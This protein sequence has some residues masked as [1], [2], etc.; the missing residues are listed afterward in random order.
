MRY[1]LGLLLSFPAVAWAQTAPLTNGPASIGPRHVCAQYYP[2]EAVAAH[3]EG[4]A[5]LSMRIKADGN[6][7]DVAVANSSG[8]KILDDASVACVQTW[9]YT[10]AV[11][12]GK[13]VDVPWK[14]LVRWGLPPD[15]APEQT[16]QGRICSRYPWR[17]R[18]DHIEGSAKV[19][20]KIAADGTVPDA[21]VTSSSGNE[22]LDEA[23]TDCIKSWTFK[24]VAGAS[25]DATHAVLV[26]WSIGGA[27]GRG[28]SSIVWKLL[29]VNLA[30]DAATRTMTDAVVTCLRN[31]PGLDDLVAGATSP[32]LVAVYYDHGAV[33][34]ASVV[35]SSGSGAL[36]KIAIGCFMSSPVD[37]ARA[38]DM[39]HVVSSVFPVQWKLILLSKAL[40][41]PPAK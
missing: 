27:S 30:S 32:T 13:P 7:A 36:D 6:V 10:P 17:P 26:T 12:N 21:S 18:I 23:A 35:S 2:P 14:A 28:G 22:D 19:S 33:S 16:G 8:Q 3:L 1:L 24:P 4:T 5:T 39:K 29:D 9:K 40:S 41:A 11:L 25:T 37:P 34:R 38:E 31:T 15:A 20:F